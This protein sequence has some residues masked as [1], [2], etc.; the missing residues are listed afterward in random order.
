MMGLWTRNGTTTV[1]PLTFHLSLG[2]MF[3]YKDKKTG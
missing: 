2:N 1:S 3:E